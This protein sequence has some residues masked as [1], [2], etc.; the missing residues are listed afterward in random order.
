MHKMLLVAA[1]AGT[2]A[3]GWIAL[4]G[5]AS[6]GRVEPGTRCTPVSVIYPGGVRKTALAPPSPGLDVRKISPH[7]VRFSWWFRVA[8]SSCRPRSLLLSVLPRGT[9]YTPWTETVAVGPLRGVYLVRLPSFYPVGSKALGSALTESGL[10]TAV[11]HV[12]IS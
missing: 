12:G 1:T 7:V 4:G 8:P 11:V 5:N 6:A 9:R 10:R 2:F 3:I